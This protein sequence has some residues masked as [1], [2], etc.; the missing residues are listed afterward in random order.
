MDGKEH[1]QGVYTYANGD[2]Y[3]GEH[4]DGKRHGQGT[5]T[6]ADGTK[7]VGEWKDE[8]KWQGTQ[9]DKDGNVTATYSEG[10]AE[11]VGEYVGELKD[12]KKHGQG[13]LTYVSGRRYV[14]EWKDGKPWEGTGYEKD[15]NVAFTYSE[16]VS[17]SAN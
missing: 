3:V 13:A 8:D 17:K 1:G 7:Y 5:L 12:G 14:G 15:G 2:K 11:F 9:Y 4:K 6:W 16:G 10:V